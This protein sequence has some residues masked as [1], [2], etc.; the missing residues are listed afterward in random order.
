[1]SE[2]DA[3]PDGYR[4]DHRG[5]L[6]PVAN[7]R[8]IDLARDA[9]VTELVADAEQ[10]RGAIADYRLRALSE[11]AAFVELSAE[12]Y[13]AKLGGTKGNVTLMSFDGV[14]KIQRAAQDVLQFDERMQAA[15]A[16][17]DGC[18]DEWTEG[19]RQELRALID[20]AFRRDAD[21][22]LNTA[23]VLAL[24]RLQIDDAQWQRAMRAIGEAVQVVASRTYL[25]IYKRDER[26]EYQPLP[27]DIARAGG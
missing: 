20:G 21:G 13:G 22:N 24:R 2:C 17:I 25:R 10:V 11:I 18:L 7:I 15:K 5:Y 6:V 19:S 26:G 14:W 27:L 12:Q 9:L 4:R 23:R 16:L 1:M 8:A 3:I